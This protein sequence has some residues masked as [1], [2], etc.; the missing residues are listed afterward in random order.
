MALDLNET[1][2]QLLEAVDSLSARRD[3]FRQ[4]LES[5]LARMGVPDTPAAIIQKQSASLGRYGFLAAGLTE[6]LASR[7]LAPQPPTDFC[8]LSTDGSHIDVDRH[9]AM[10]AY[11]INIGGCFL[12]YGANPDAHL[13]SQ[14]RLYVRDEDLYLVDEDCQ[15]NTVPVEGAV[16]GLV[17]A[18]REVEALRELARR[19]PP[20]LPC[21]ALLDGSLVLW[22]LAGQGYPAFLARQ[23]I[24]RGLVP[25]LDW[26]R[27]LSRTRPL[28]LA[29]YI[30]LPG[31][32]EVVN[33]LRLALCP[34]PV[35]DC[36]QHCGQVRAGQRPCDT[37][38][39][40]L[41]R[42][43]F[44]SLLE[45]GQ[46]SS[47]FQSHSSVVREHYGDHQVFF[48]YVNVGEEVARVEVPLWV[49]QDR[50]LLDLTHALVL[51]QCRR[52]RGY[53]VAIA[54]AHEQA[55]VTGQDRELF[56]QMVEQSLG[57]QHLPVFTSEKNLS[58]RRRWV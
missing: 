37:V 9:L 56:R 11:L 14:P 49:A 12:T 6:D 55:V 36:R 33:A 52:G 35:A 50:R 42:H 25:A 44:G 54:E 17:R 31:S 46:R 19:A 41:D 47:L 18:V 39:G 16:L 38:H 5:A 21:L 15:V 22:G 43:L 32:T 40:F 1:I 58:K 13:F 24:G 8:V 45:P 3:D 7:H 26:L 23:I 48:Y 30:S 20:D 10:R 4:R 29:A 28:A 53:P 57:S 34:Y 2:R 27:E 51:D